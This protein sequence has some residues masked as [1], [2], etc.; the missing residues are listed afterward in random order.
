MHPL[1]SLFRENGINNVYWVIIWVWRVAEQVILAIL[2]FNNVIIKIFCQGNPKFEGQVYKA[3]IALLRA[4]SPKAQQM[5][6][7]TLRIVQVKI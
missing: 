1:R 2:N 5:A 6:A 4:S 3:L 7:E